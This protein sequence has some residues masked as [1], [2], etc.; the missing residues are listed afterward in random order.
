MKHRWRI[1]VATLFVAIVVAGALQLGGNLRPSRSCRRC[2]RLVC[3]RC[4]AKFGAGEL[5]EACNRLFYQPE[6]TD[7]E[8]RLARVDALR[9]R[10]KRIDKLAWLASLLLPG[11]AGVLANRA[12]RSLRGFDATRFYYAD[13][14]RNDRT[15]KPDRART[16]ASLAVGVDLVFHAGH[17]N[18]D[19]W[20]HSLQ[21]ADVDRLTNVRTPVIFSAGCSTAASLP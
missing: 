1:A 5:C 12:L 18:P 19:R 2:G 6:H 4:D 16:L 20:Q 15:P 14:A 21:L 11:V 9:E 7:R 13:R 8:L 17:G 10:E 3:P